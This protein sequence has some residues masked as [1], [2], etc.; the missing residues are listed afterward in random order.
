MRTGQQQTGLIVAHAGRLAQVG[1]PLRHRLG[2]TRMT[3][4]FVFRRRQLMMNLIVLVSGRRPSTFINAVFLV[5]RDAAD[6]LLSF[7]LKST[8]ITNS[9]PLV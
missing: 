3:A 1:Q 4:C 2:S 9:L 8:F 7:L 6:Y 5:L